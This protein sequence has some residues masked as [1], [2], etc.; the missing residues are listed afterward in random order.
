M[1]SLGSVTKLQIPRRML[2]FEGFLDLPSLRSHERFGYSPRAAP[3]PILIQ[4]E[5]TQTPTLYSDRN[6]NLPELGTIVCRQNQRLCQRASLY[7]FGADTPDLIKQEI[8][9]ELR[10]TLFRTP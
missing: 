7:C 8:C 9:K 4:N 3:L 5:V 1:V 2:R 10:M 6:P